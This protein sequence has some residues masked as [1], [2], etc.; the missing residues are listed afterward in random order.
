MGICRFKTLVCLSFINAFNYFHVDASQAF[1]W[2]QR[3]PVSSEPF[4][5][6][7]QNEV[8]GDKIK[9]NKKNSLLYLMWL[10]SQS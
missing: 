3:Y 7:I 5:S 8:H 9:I 4:N 1:A 10:K 2:Q 6:L